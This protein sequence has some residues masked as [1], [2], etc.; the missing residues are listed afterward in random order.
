M[1]INFTGND[2]P[3]R[4]TPMTESIM[5]AAGNK[6]EG[7]KDFRTSWRDREGDKGFRLAQVVFI[8]W[9]IHSSY[10]VLAGVYTTKIQS[11]DSFRTQD[12]TRRDVAMDIDGRVDMCAF[13]LNSHLRLLGIWFWPVYHGIRRLRTPSRRSRGKRFVAHIT[14]GSRARGGTKGWGPAPIC[15]F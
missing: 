15:E 3:F 8:H 2:L 11:L 14:T 5:H 13:L 7:M 12:T 1:K 10:I 9:F 6:H 4:T